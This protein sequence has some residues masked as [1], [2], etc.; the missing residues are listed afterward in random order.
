MFLALD[1]PESFSTTLTDE[2]GGFKTYDLIADEVIPMV[3]LEY[4]P[5]G[6]EATV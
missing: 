6:M 1:R 2:L 5:L 3:L 4:L